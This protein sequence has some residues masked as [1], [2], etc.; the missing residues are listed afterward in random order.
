MVVATTG[1]VD[2]AVGQRPRLVDPSGPVRL[3]ERRDEQEARRGALADL[4]HGPLGAGQ[5]AAGLGHVA[6]EHED[7]PGPEGTP[8]RRPCITP[9]EGGPRAP[10]PRPHAL[11][12]VPRQVRRDGQS[13]EILGTELVARRSGAR[14]PP[15]TLCAQRPRGLSR[16]TTRPFSPPRQRC[17][18][19][20]VGRSAGWDE[21]VTS[22]T[23][24]D[25]L[26]PGSTSDSERCHTG[27]SPA[28][29]TLNP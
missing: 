8:C 6:M 2:D 1:D 20:L 26:S 21:S 12:V 22:T 29:S 15:P 3:Q 7:E 11:V 16:T 10:V 27:L 14:R 23:S 5:P 17:A 9:L 18:G 24:V 13:L 28:V 4:R 25:R 19:S